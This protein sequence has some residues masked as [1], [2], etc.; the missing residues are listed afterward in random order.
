MQGICIAFS[1][2]ARTRLYQDGELNILFQ[3]GLEKDSSMPADIPLATE[4]TAG[5]K[6]DTDALRLFLA[7]AALG[8]PFMAPPGV[9]AGRMAILRKA[10]AD[11]MADTAFVEEAQKLKLTVEP[12]SG[13]ELGNIIRDIY[14]TPPDVV[15]KVSKI[16][17]HLSGPAQQ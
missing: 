6:A 5:N 4:L 16:L 3:A 9:P 11:T 14:R 7:R 8:R 2:I 10:F 1:S 17:G 12:I 15:Q 13:E